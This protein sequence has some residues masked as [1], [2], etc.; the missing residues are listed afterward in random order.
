MTAVGHGAEATRWV[1]RAVAAVLA[2]WVRSP[3]DRRPPVRAARPAAVQPRGLPYVHTPSTNDWL[4]DPNRLPGHPTGQK[5]LDVGA[6]QI[7][8]GGDVRELE[9]S[10]R[11]P[12][13]SDT[14]CR[15]DE[16]HG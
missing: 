7:H 9:A 5:P 3:R 13:C 11:L 2:V 1:Y 8:P 16:L 4:T 14:A 10:S 6:P 15:R 12:D